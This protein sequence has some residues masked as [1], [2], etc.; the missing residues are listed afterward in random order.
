MNY[1]HT[2]LIPLIDYRNFMAGETYEAFEL[3]SKVKRAAD[4]LISWR[5][6]P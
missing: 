2:G 5:D 3:F 1:N 4:A 6:G